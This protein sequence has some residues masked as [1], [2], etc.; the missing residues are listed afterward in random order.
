MTGQG[1]RDS[2]EKVGAEK[3]L[4]MRCSG[5]PSSEKQ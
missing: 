1:F 2:V 3:L 4:A 5:S